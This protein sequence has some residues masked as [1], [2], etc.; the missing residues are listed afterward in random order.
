M[1][2]PYKTKRLF[3]YTDSKLKSLVFDIVSRSELLNLTVSY[4]KG[5]MDAE[6]VDSKSGKMFFHNYEAIKKNLKVMVEQSNTSKEDIR[7]MLVVYQNNVE[8]TGEYVFSIVDETKA[9]NRRLMELKELA[10]TANTTKSNFLASMSHEIRTPMNAISGMAELLLRGQLSSEA[11][12]YAQDIKNASANLIAI[13][14]DI[15]DFSKIEAGKLE[16]VPVK[17]LISSVLNDVVNIIRMRIMEKPMRFF[18][19]IDSAIPNSLVGDEVRIRQ[20]LLNLLSNAVK[21]SERGLVGLSIT[22]EKDDGKQVLLKI[23]VSD[24]GK[25]IKP[26]DQA[27]LFSDFVQVDTTKNRGIE[28]TGLGLAIVRRLCQAMGGDITVQS[29]YGAGSTFTAHFPQEIDS[30]A[31]CA[32]VE[33]PEKK[34]T[35]VYERRA[36]YAESV[37]WSLHNMG[38]PHAMV[39]NAEDFAAALHREE[40]AF[41]ISGY[42]LYEHIRPL[43]GQPIS[44]FPGG[45]KPS[46]AL[47]V[48]WGTEAN[49]SDVRFLSVPVQTASI[50][51]VLNGKTD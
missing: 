26:E 47:M 44:A 20:I 5:S 3:H 29:Q 12:S 50:A 17:Y 7:K 49:L 32:L 28:G 41:V 35:L 8:Q 46:L 45:R 33:E 31:P 25:G 34:K 6:S 27:K 43:M 37:C 10:E 24:T 18:V 22:R 15:L 9:Q 39:T 1:A 21:Y 2:D 51:N 36:V 23:A 40:W 48:E 30:C 11:R 42:G 16:I 4:L 38:I 13:I 14:N 19:N